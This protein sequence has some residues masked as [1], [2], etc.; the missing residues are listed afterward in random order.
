[1]NET[2]ILYGDAEA[3]GPTVTGGCLTDKSVTI[4]PNP[5]PIG[6]YDITGSKT[7]AGSI[8]FM[9]PKKPNWFHR[10]CCRF[11]LGWKWVEDK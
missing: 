5:K 4:V 6:G 10:M 8:R 11:F 3:I 7:V 2:K 9:F 1:M